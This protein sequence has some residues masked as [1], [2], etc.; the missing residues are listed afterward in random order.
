MYACGLLACGMYECA[1]VFHECLCMNNLLV[2]VCGEHACMSRLCSL[3]V[4][5]GIRVL[6]PFTS[7]C[8]MLMVCAYHVHVYVYILSR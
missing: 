4:R 1:R 5:T 3:C 8:G 6:R 2:C 7:A